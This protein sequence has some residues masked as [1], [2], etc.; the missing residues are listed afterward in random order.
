MVKTR[1]ANLPT[2]YH[3]EDNFYTIPN[4]LSSSRSTRTIRHILTP[5]PR[6]ATFERIPRTMSP[7]LLRQ[8]L[9]TMTFHWT[10]HTQSHLPACTIQQAAEEEVW[11][12][13]ITFSHTNLVVRKLNLAAAISFKSPSIFVPHTPLVQWGS[14]GD[15]AK[16]EGEDERYN[17]QIGMCG[18]YFKSLFN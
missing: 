5:F 13:R 2:I 7:L 3:F 9:P 4:R 14:G 16:D 11:I 10:T 18:M 1:Y 15:Q 8:W 17:H 12:Y 6:T